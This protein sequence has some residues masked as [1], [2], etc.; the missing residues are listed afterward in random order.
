MAKRFYSRPARSSVGRFRPRKGC[1]PSGDREVP[2]TSVR[3][4]RARG[5]ASAEELALL[6][7][8]TAQVARMGCRGRKAKPARTLA[9]WAQ[10]TEVF[11]DL[12]A[13]AETGILKSPQ[14]DSPPQKAD[15]DTVPWRYGVK[16]Y[17]R[18]TLSEGVR[19]VRIAPSQK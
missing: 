1:E 13:Y 6:A 19:D 7:L 9:P 12:E 16:L 3:A 17:N 8:H 5:K 4:T 18:H 11:P 10:G 2:V 14:N 15:G